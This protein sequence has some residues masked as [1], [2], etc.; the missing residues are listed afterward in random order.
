MFMVLCSLEAVRSG[1]L[2]VATGVLDFVERRLEGSRSPF[3]RLPLCT[4]VVSCCVV[5]IGAAVAHE[6]YRCLSQSL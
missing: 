1:S 5:S 4:L 2:A 6:T 3:I